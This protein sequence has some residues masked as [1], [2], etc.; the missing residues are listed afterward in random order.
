MLTVPRKVLNNS[1][2]L[3]KRLQLNGGDTSLSYSTQDGYL[4]GEN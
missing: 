4:T 2:D 3:C 1:E